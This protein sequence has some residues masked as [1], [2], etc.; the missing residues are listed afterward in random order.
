MGGG[1]FTFRGPVVMGNRQLFSP[2]PMRRVTVSPCKCIAPDPCPLDQLHHDSIAAGQRPRQHPHKRTAC[3][4]ICIGDCAESQNVHLQLAMFQNMEQ[5][6][7]NSQ[8]AC[9]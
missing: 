3:F 8:K 7:V 2:F 9:P 5:M 6:L 1:L 4:V